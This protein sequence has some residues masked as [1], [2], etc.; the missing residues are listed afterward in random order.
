V[1]KLAKKFNLLVSR[2]STSG[3]EGAEVYAS[4]WMLLT[5]D[6]NLHGIFEA[7]ENSKPPPK[8]P[9][10]VPLWTDGHTNLFQILMENNEDEN[11][12]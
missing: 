7:A 11:E 2:I 10:D 8:K 6:A 5:K 9:R 3:N 12:E 4:D 1:D